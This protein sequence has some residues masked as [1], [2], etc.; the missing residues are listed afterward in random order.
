MST[1]W[2]GLPPGEAAQRDGWHWLSSRYADTPEPCLWDA[3]QQQWQYAGWCVPEYVSKQAVY[4][5][6]CLTP[7]EIAALTAA[8]H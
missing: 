6:P 8:A 1:E 3:D 4:L 2:D 5:G 7:A